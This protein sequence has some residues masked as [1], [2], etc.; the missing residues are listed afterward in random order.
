M[1][2]VVFSS[3]DS[4]EMSFPII[5][6]FSHE[7]RHHGEYRQ[8][9]QWYD[10]VVKRQFWRYVNV[11]GRRSRGLGNGNLR[12]GEGGKRSIRC[13]ES[14]GTSPCDGNI[15]LERSIEVWVESERPESQDVRGILDSGHTL[16]LLKTVPPKGFPMGWY[17]YP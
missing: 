17:V 3:A 14:K 10:S 13:V 2:H 6:I 1:N 12:R 16:V 5:R 4:P 15:D 8:C 11:I 7:L 9:I